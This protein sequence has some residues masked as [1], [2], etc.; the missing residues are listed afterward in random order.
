MCVSQKHRGG[1]WIEAY[2]DWD[3][4]RLGALSRP[5]LKVC[6]GEGLTLARSTQWQ[7]TS[8]E[9]MYADLY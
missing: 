5:N 8:Q 7:M 2:S 9:M 3:T 1:I 6:K 4:G